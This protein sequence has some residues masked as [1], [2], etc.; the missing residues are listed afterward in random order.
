MRSH[1]IY[2]G[3]T[4]KSWKEEGVPPYWFKKCYEIQDGGNQVYLILWERAFL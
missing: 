1:E 2:A 3:D 4:E